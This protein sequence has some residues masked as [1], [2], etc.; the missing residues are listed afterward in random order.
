MRV[1]TVIDAL[2]LGGAESLV[3]QLARVCS[4]V[5]VELSVLSLHEDRP[6]YSRLAPQLR[7]AGV[8]PG[9]LGARRTL[10]PLAFRRLVEHIRR[11]KPDVVHAHLEMAMTMAVPAA[12][13]AGVPVVCTFHHVHGPHH[14]HGRPSRRDRV[15]ERLALEVAT[16]GDATLF[17]SRASL[18]SFADRYRAGRPV[19]ASWRVVHNGV[20]L[21]H[22]SPGDGD[23][24]LP[25]DLGAGVARVVTVL[26]RRD[27]VKGI[28]HAI[29]AWPAVLAVA[30][31]V[32]LLLVGGPGSAE[33][34]LRRKVGELHLAGSVLFAGMRS[35][36][37]DI[38]RSSEAV[39]LPSV[40]GENL[41]TVLMEAGGCGRPVVAS[42]VGGIGDIVVDGE[43]GFLVPPGDPEAI[44]RA[45]TR[46]LEE[47]HLAAALGA[48]GRQRMERLFDARVW[49][50][51]LRSVYEEVAS[52]TQRTRRPT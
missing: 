51:S 40:H 50:R 44:A 9:Y 39:L 36:I 21:D 52:S 38:L 27:D 5:D 43:T 45:V 24:P 13:L 22:F 41:P 31:D 12:A 4:D 16:R 7:E 28:V 14:R 33:E 29:E 23:A 47:P 10:D 32:K 26:A 34:A 18:T 37:T 11:T 35:D 42:D 49:A 20:D 3:V 17:V 8:E 25:P 1:L 6:E 46:L 19:P 2:R 30:P 48:A 15:R